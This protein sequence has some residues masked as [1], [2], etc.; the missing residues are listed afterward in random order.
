MQLT[1][2]EWQALLQA[3]AE[4]EAGE[5][6]ESMGWDKRLSLALY[7]AL[8]KLRNPDSTEGSTQQE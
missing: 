3:A 7:S 8:K 6:H 4:V 5:M 1:K 2:A